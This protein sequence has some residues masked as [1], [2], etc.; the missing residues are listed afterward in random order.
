MRKILVKGAPINDRNDGPHGVG[1]WLA[2]LVVGMLVLGPLL[3]IG[4]TY[5]EFA[6][7]EHQYSELA[8]LADWSSFKTAEWVVLL[9]FCGISIYGGHGLATKRTPDA[10]SRAK[11]VLWFNYPIGIVV[12]AMIIPALMLPGGGKAAATA[13]PSLLASL[14]AVAIWTAYLNRSKRVKN[15]YFLRIVQPT[16]ETHVHCPDCRK[17]IPMEARTCE[18]C[19]CKLIPQGPLVT[20]KPGAISQSVPP[21]QQRSQPA[22][23]AQQVGA[24]KDSSHQNDEALYEQALTE[25]STNKK[26]GLWAMALAQTANGGNPDGAYIALR[27]EQLR[28][29]NAQS[30]S[31]ANFVASANGVSSVANSQTGTIGI[32]EPE[33]SSS[34]NKSTEQVESAKRAKSGLWFIIIIIFFYALVAF[35]VR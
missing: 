15:T 32:K 6:S 23:A 33:S 12:T 4:R 8:S 27:V 19:G 10:V 2:L 29:D 18:H 17:L 22:A 35:V 13:I 31:A 26:P 3:G 9:I 21:P 28:L 7:I 34:L 11:L 16:P 1:G 14:I 25:L 30:A 5:V 20:E 24:S